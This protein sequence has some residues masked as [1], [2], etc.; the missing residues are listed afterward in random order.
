MSTASSHRTRHLREQKESVSVCLCL[1]LVASCSNRAPVFGSCLPLTSPPIRV[2]ARTF[3][4]LGF[5]RLTQPREELRVELSCLLASLFEEQRRPAG[6]GGSEQ[7]KS[8]CARDRA[9][10][11]PVLLTM[12]LWK[13]GLVPLFS[14]ACRVNCETAIRGAGGTCVIAAS[15]ARFFYAGTLHRASTYCT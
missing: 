8:S 6:P 12:L 11:P 5:V 15:S 1:A 3:D 4:A 14:R 13:S 10:A 7:T 2:A 9:R